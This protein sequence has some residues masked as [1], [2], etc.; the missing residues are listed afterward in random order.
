MLQTGG[1]ISG[2]AINWQAGHFDRQ[3]GA[4]GRPKASL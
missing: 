1:Q 4:S 3:F 2:S